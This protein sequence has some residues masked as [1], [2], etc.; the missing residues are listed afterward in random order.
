M[1]VRMRLSGISSTFDP[2]DIECLVRTA[3]EAV[4]GRF[5]DLSDKQL[6]VAVQAYE[7][8]QDEMSRHD[9]A[10]AE[11]R[12][13]A[14]IDSA[15]K[16]FTADETM[17]GAMAQGYTPDQVEAVLGYL[18]ERSGLHL[19]CV[20]DFHDTF[21]FGGNSSFYI[22]ADGYFHDL[23]GDLWGWLNRPGGDPD[24]PATPGHPHDWVGVMSTEVAM[25]D[26]EFTDDGDHN[27]ARE[28]R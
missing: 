9:P 13:R 17:R 2:D 19:V 25:S 14:V 3:A 5:E 8:L 21:G 4:H 10:T 22:E 15:A 23:V 24:A 26:I 6:A 28:V 7:Q 12:R 11:A 1:A 16:T 18:G 20:W 27:Y